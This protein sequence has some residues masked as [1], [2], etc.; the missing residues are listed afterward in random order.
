MCLWFSWWLYGLYEGYIGFLSW[1][2]KLWVVF[3]VSWALGLSRAKGPFRDSHV[4][5]VSS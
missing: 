5:S 1:C 4:F 2:C 3:V